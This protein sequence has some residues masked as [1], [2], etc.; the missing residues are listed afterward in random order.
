MPVAPY[1][2]LPYQILIDGQ[3]LPEPVCGGLSRLELRESDAEASMAALCF[4]VAGESSRPCGGMLRPLAHLVVAVAAPGEPLECLFSGCV[5]H[6]RPL[7]GALP[8]RRGVEVLAV[9]ESALLEVHERE[10]GYGEGHQCRS[11]LQAQSH[12]RWVELRRVATG[13]LRHASVVEVRGEVDCAHYGGLLR[14]R[15]TVLLK[16][17]GRTFSGDYY[18]HSV[19]TTLEA[20]LL[21]Q[22]F[23]ALGKA[24]PLAAWEPLPGPRV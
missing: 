17:V 10:C 5:T 16:G 8:L 7:Q 12:L 20:G 18:V 21:T 11:T 13:P 2:I 14:A 23:I 15:H 9:E 4:S 22:S 1:Q 3:S 24:P 19:C 6:V